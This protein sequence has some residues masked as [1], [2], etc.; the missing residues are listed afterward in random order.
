MADSSAQPHGRRDAWGHHFLGGLE[1]ALEH[2]RLSL[3][4]LHCAALPDV[5]HL[6]QL[7]LLRSLN[8]S[9]A[10]ERPAVWPVSLKVR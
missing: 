5:A 6:V 7:K 1:S 4:E 10:P 8:I 3:T 9:L 2:L